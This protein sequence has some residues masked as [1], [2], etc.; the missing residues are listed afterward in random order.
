VTAIVRAAVEGLSEGRRLLDDAASH[1]LGRVLRVAAGQAVELFD[2]RARATA[3]AIVVGADASGRLLVE[4]GP[5]VAAPPP[6]PEITLLYSISKGDKADMVVEDAT[7]LGATRVVIVRA[8]RS[9]VKLDDRRAAARR[10]R[11][12]RIAT[13]AARQ[14]GRADVPSVEGVLDLEVAAGAATAASRFAL[15]PSGLSLRGPLVDAVA[16]LDSLAFAIGP[17]GG[18]DDEEIR[19]LETRGY[20]L[21]SFGDT[22]LRTE[23]VAAAVLGAVRVLA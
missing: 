1:H 8:R 10:A 17:E 23:T 13:A 6:R 11:W 14:C 3:S 2:P 20:R 4:V 9:V 18:F 12:T 15:H 21:A 16:R 7:E 19:A 5:L 22:V